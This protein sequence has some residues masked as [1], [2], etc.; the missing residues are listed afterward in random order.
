MISKED[1]AIAQELRNLVTRMSRRL[2]KQ[3]SNPDA[4]SIAEGNVI[5]ILMNHKALYPSALGAQLNISSQFMSQILNR[6]EKLEYIARKSAPE[7]G[8][9]TLVSL[10]RK[11]KHMVEESRQEREEWLAQV[12]AGKYNNHQKKLIKEALSLLIEVTEL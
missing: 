5:S 10:T 12:I 1:Q 2:R 7:D 9:K 6:L 3:I 8:R 4:L 11:G